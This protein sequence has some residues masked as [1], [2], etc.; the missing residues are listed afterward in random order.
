[1]DLS[2]S[3]RSHFPALRSKPGF[4]TTIASLTEGPARRTAVIRLAGQCRSLDSNRV[5]L[6]PTSINELAVSPL[7]GALG[8]HQVHLRSRRAILR[9]LIQK[10]GG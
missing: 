1:M 9:Q 10:H 5:D 3:E 4:V 7:P 6:G 8:E 2:G